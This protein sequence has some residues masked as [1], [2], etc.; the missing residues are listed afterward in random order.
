VRAELERINGVSEKDSGVTKFR[1]GYKEF[2][3]PDKDG[4]PQL[5]PVPAFHVWPRDGANFFIALPNAD[6][7]FTCT[8]FSLTSDPEC[9]T[10]FSED[11][12]VDYFKKE[13]PDVATLMGAEKIRHDHQTNPFSG[14]YNV[15]V[16]KWYYS[17]DV[18]VMG[19]AAHGIVP[20][21][22]L[23][24]NGG[25]E[26][27]R[28]MYNLVKKYS[29]NGKAQWD[30]IF[31]EFNKYKMHM[32]VLRLASMKNADELHVHVKDTH[33]LFEKEVERELQKKYPNQFIEAHA[34]LSFTDVPLEVCGNHIKLQQQLTKELCHGKSKLQEID[35]NLASDLVSTRLSN[36]FSQK[37]WY[38][39]E[40]RTSKL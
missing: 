5:D 1:A 31:S 29:K 23:G 21:Y 33:F 30:I 13:F 19:D 28:H 40:N 38:E 34:L 8:M 6:N 20:Y 24:I 15:N 26:G 27:C 22:G 18:V 36:L 10:N 11:Q 3:I 35:W 39:N 17:G 2:E 9:I 12:I 14:L 32:D 7:T 16:E 25:F 4:K 37:M